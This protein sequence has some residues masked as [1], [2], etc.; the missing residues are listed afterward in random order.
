MWHLNDLLSFAKSCSAKNHLEACIEISKFILKDYPNCDEAFFQLAQINLSQKHSREAYVNIVHA[1]E[2]QPHN[3]AYIRLQSEIVQ[4]LQSIGETLETGSSVS[5]M[6]DNIDDGVDGF[7]DFSAVDL[8]TPPPKRENIVIQEILYLD[9]SPNDYEFGIKKFLKDHSLQ[10]DQ[11]SIYA[12]SKSDIDVLRTLKYS[13][14]GGKIEWLALNEQ[15]WDKS[16]AEDCQQIQ[17]IYDTNS[18]ALFIHL[19]DNENVRDI[20]RYFINHTKLFSLEGRIFSEAKIVFLNRNRGQRDPLEHLNPY[21]LVFVAATNSGRDRFIPGLLHLASKMKRPVKQ[22]VLYL[23]SPARRDRILHANALHRGASTH[24]ELREYSDTMM[25]YGEEFVENLDFFDVG[26][27]HQPFP[28]ELISK[29]RY[30]DC[31]ALMRDPRDACTSYGFSTRWPRPNPDDKNWEVTGK[32]IVEDTMMIFVEEFLERICT[33][34]VEIQNSPACFVVRFEDLHNDAFG[35]YARLL[36]WLD[37]THEIRADDISQAIYLGTFEYQSGGTRKR[38]QGEETTFGPHGDLR[39]GAIGDWRNFM[40]PAVK[41]K[42]KQKVGA[43][44]IELGYADDLNW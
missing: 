31:V 42:I 14:L 11:F 32:K 44:L 18:K 26:L 21:S 19:S 24:S 28:V 1:L 7:M 40:T 13:G 8:P 20:V 33:H 34:F 15:N 29:F 25:A 12:N 17:R 16:F 5:Q 6:Y 30:V 35:V 41:E 43:Q 10:N 27:M 37:W 38:G 9:L 4:Q 2:L 39:K 36:K 22:N 3:P 23:N